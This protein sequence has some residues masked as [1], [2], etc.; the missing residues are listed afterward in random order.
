MGRYLGVFLAALAADVAVWHLLSYRVQT[1]M[2]IGG[3]AGLVVALAIV[4]LSGLQRRARHL[5]T[6][7]LVLSTLMSLALILLLPLLQPLAAWA[8]SALAAFGFALI[9][10]ALYMRTPKD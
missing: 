10:F 9:G 4:Q 7:S 8:F 3:V 5:L 1:T 6:I 2:L